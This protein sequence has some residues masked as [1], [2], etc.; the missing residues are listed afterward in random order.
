M[1][2]LWVL[3]AASAQ[4][5]SGAGVLP[6]DTIEVVYDRRVTD[7]GSII[8]LSGATVSGIGIDHPAE[9]LN[10]A[11]G[12]NIQMGSGQEHLIALRS[13][14]LNGG[15]G[16]GS[17]LVLLDGLPVRAAPFGNVNGLLELPYEVADG[18]EI[19]K[20]P[21]SAKYGSNAV[22]GIVNLQSLRPDDTSRYALASVGTLGRVRFDGVGGPKEG[23][24]R[25]YLIGRG[26]HGWRSASGGSQQKI[27]A[28]KSWETGAWAL[29]AAFDASNLNQETAGFVQ[30]GEAY[31]DDSLTHGNANPEAFRDAKWGR[32]SV[33]ARRNGVLVAP[34]LISQRMRFRQHF[35]PYKGLEENGHDAVGLTVQSTRATSRGE[36]MWG[37]D[38]QAARGFLTETQADPFGF[39]SGDTRFPVGR[40]YDYDVDTRSLALFGEVRGAVLPHLSVVAGIRGET[41]AFDYRTNIPAGT[42]GRFRVAEDRKDNFSFVAP[43][44]GAIWQASDRIALYAN[45]SRGARAPQV[46][47][48][49]RLQNLQT[50]GAA[51][52]ET[53]DSLE[54]GLRGR[55]TEGISFELAAFGMD[56]ENFFF[57]DADGLNV[58]DGAT[59][60]RGI[61]LSVTRKPLRGFFWSASLSYAEHTYAF[62]RPVVRETETIRDGNLIDT[63]PKW[64]ADGEIGFQGA[65]WQA[66][67]FVDHVGDYFT[68]AANLHRYPGHTVWTARAQASLGDQLTASATVK[69]VGDA[70]YADRADFAFGNERY[71]PG[72]PRSIEVGIRRSF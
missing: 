65:N 40:H 71:F 43:K 62:D 45:Y 31:K 15:A 38:G 57:R 7:P 72:E 41:H 17:F 14:V 56:K 54:L 51:Q 8:R 11:A 66:G 60:H 16:Q 28:R 24:A 39:F 25:G 70:A 69:N 9:A 34:Y 53:A 36:L 10:R 48:L 32:L 59:R 68:D 13:P 46:S 1:G 2:V 37:A 5:S 55:V 63:A 18:V 64:L 61:D 30:G 52:V 58:T 50:P 23:G 27:G 22:H 19:I 21:G 42:F 47:D 35:L 3:A 12:V 4:V 44:L 49:Y 33:Q 29:H 6:D 26:D 20:G 67:F